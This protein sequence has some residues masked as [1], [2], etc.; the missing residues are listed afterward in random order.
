MSQPR[1][2]A[3]ELP[4]SSRTP[5]R[6]EL[7]YRSDTALLVTYATHLVRSELTVWTETP[8][9][10]GTPLAL[11]LTAPTMSIDVDGVVSLT[12][13]DSGGRP[14]FAAMEVA[15]TSPLESL[16]EAVDRLAF[17]FRGIR[18]LV[19]AS[20]AAPRAHLTRYLRTIIN[21]EVA[22][23]DQKKLGE[24][25]ATGNV[26]V[27]V[28]DLDSTGP[29]GY[30]LYAQLRQ[31]PE[32]GS[33]PVLALAQLERDRARAASLGFDEALA[34]PPAFAELQAG[35]LRALAKPTRVTVFE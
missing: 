29:A 6:I 23:A 9:R 34:N 8:F 15:L 10:T 13:A 1:F 21:C 16:G 26:D 25:G 22:E 33:A 19:A 17:G 30:D 27:T 2:A 12:R 32:V 24:P 35:L 5:V 20:Q 14:H 3:G 18:A 7:S 28:I 4:T 11:R 31:H